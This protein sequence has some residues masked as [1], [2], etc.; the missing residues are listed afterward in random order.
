VASSYVVDTDSGIEVD[1]QKLSAPYTITV[2]GDAQTMRT[3]LNIAGGVVESVGQ[4]GGTV[5]VQ[6]PGA[7]EVKT[8]HTAASPR[9]AHPVN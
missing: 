6:E 5:T 4:A 3:A 9:F 2:I 8:L 1:G 7:V